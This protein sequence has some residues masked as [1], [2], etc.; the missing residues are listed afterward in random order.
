[1][2]FSIIIPVYN[3]EQYISASI[4]SVLSQSEDSRE[5]I[6]INDGSTDRTKKICSDYSKKYP[7]IKLINKE[8]SGVSDARN[9]GLENATGDYILF[10]DADDELAD[11]ALET[12]ERVIENEN[13]PDI[14]LANYCMKLNDKCRNTG[15]MCNTVIDNRDHH[16]V[17]NVLDFYRARDNTFGNLRTIWAKAYSKKLL[18][19]VRFNSQLKIGEDMLF[20]LECVFLAVRIVCV[21]DTVYVYR[22]HEASVMQ[23]KKWKRIHNNLAYYELVKET[24][25]RYQ[26]QNDLFALWLEIYESEWY[27][28]IGSDCSFVFKYWTL[29]KYRKDANFQKYSHSARNLSKV[30]KIYLT[31]IRYHLI[32]LWMLLIHVKYKRTQKRFTA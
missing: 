8:N 23:S 25:E 13:N 30:E 22:I 6:I 18:E 4:E 1:M 3:C 14:I 20:F 15:D 2:R 17:S 26:Y 24:I 28:L 16:F 10:L 32:L 11:G 7:F 19:S 27:D 12:F 5:I 31:S 9:I 21:S 29:C